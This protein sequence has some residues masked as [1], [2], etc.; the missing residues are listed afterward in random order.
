MAGKADCTLGRRPTDLLSRQA[1]LLLSRTGAS[2]GMI[3]TVARDE[4][5]LR[6]LTELLLDEGSSLRPS[7]SAP[8]A[9]PTA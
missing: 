4:E 5:Q 6:S 7:V 9:P 1:S 8:L 2:L 3:Q